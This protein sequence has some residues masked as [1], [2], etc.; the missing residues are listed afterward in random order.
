MCVFFILIGYGY[1]HIIIKILLI[2]SIVSIFLC[3]FIKIYCTAVLK[4]P[5]CNKHLT[6]L[7]HGE[8]HYKS[9]DHSGKGGEA[10]ILKD[11]LTGII[12]CMHCGKKVNTND[13]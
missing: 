7:G 11:W 3:F 1:N 12:F 6:V 5:H 8:P 9:L 2:V 13:L 10:L 4:C